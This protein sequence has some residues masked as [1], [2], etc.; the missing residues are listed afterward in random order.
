MPLAKQFHLHELLARVD[1]ELRLVSARPRHAYAYTV[2]MELVVEGSFSWATRSLPD[3][4]VDVVHFRRRDHTRRPTAP[5]VRVSPTA[6]LPAAR[7]PLTPAQR[8]SWADLARP[9][10][11]APMQT[12]PAGAPSASLL[13]PAAASGPPPVPVYPDDAVVPTRS[14]RPALTSSSSPARGPASSPSTASPS[15]PAA[16]PPPQARAPGKGRGA[17]RTQPTIAPFMTAGRTAP[18]SST[19]APPAVTRSSP[20]GGPPSAASFSSPAAASPAAPTVPVGSGGAPDLGALMAQ[21][22]AQFAALQATI[23]AAVAPLQQAMVVQ[24]QLHESLELRLQMVVDDVA[25]LKGDASL[26]RRVSDRVSPASSG[27]TRARSAEPERS[28]D[29]DDGGLDGDDA[30]M[31]DAVTEAAARRR[32]GKQGRITP[33]SK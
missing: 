22:Q 15:P 5:P 32:H 3:V 7:R 18:P 25:A 1:P 21:M 26:A 17:G 24:R 19:P 14:R 13:P 28:S 30:P 12:D 10:A 6:S 11:T 16:T 9:A 2:E 29:S 8:T 33:P 27:R 23:T 20:S 4:G 31:H